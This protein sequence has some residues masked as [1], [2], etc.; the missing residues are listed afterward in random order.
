MKNPFI[1]RILKNMVLLCSIAITPYASADLSDGFPIGLIYSVDYKK[2]I[3]TVTN[4][5]TGKRHTYF[6]NEKSKISSMGQKITLEDVKPGHA[7]A[8][9]F[10]RTDIG[11]EVEFLRVPD[12][13]STQPLPEISEEAEY[14]ISGVVTGVR[15]K[16]RY[17]TV[18][19]P[20]VT[21]RMSIYVPDNAPIYMGD[22]KVKLSKVSRGDVLEVRYRESE[23][24][25]VLVSG[26]LMKKDM[27]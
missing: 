25:F 18:R 6:L 20:K 15:P 2:Q 24:G 5:D 4:L 17:V 27:N 3:I 10:K 19:G 26:D 21:L 9:D 12:L 16:L 22:Q 8:M 14:F 7:V 23:F 1:P 11:R 13:D